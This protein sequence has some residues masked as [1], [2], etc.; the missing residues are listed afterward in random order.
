MLPRF[1]E[2]KERPRLRQ[3]TAGRHQIEYAI[4]C[5]ESNPSE[6]VKTTSVSAPISSAVRL[7]FLED[8]GLAVSYMG[9]RPELHPREPNLAV[10]AQSP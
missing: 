7:I 2:R 9:Y 1:S 5:G 6:F 8:A 10:L 3:G 4:E